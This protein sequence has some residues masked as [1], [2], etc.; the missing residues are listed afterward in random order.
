MKKILPLF[1]AAMI[2]FSACDDDDD[3]N[4]VNNTNNNINNTNNS[5]NTNNTNNT[6]NCNCEEWQY[7]DASS[8]CQISEGRC[9]EPAHCSGTL[10]VC[11]LETHVCVAADCNPACGPFEDCVLDENDN[12]ECVDKTLAWQHFPITIV[13][14]IVNGTSL[15]SPVDGISFAVRETTGEI[16][17]SF[18]SDYDDPNEVFLWHVDGS[19]NHSKKLLS[20]TPFTGTTAFCVGE[21]NWCQF[22]AWDEANDS[23]V[24][25]GPSTDAFMSVSATTWEAT[26]T[27]VTGTHPPD[28]HIS[29]THTFADGAFYLY[30]STGPSG[31][32]NSLYR[33]DIASAQWETIA[34]GLPQI[35]DNCLAVDTD[36]GYVWSFG[37]RLTTDGGNTTSNLDAV[38]RISIDTG[39]VVQTTFPFGPRKGMSCT[40]DPD[41]NMVFIHGGNIVNDNWNDALN[42]FY[43]DLWVFDPVGNTFTELIP[44]TEGGTLTAPDSY[45]DQS[46]EGDPDGPN[47]GKNRGL[48]RYDSA[49]QRL[50]LIGAVPIFTH[51]QIYYLQF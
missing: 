10:P 17:T 32:G 24:I 45:G 48:M 12:P 13:D 44:L 20:G 50:V 41:Y 1:I 33:F 42:E 7:C 49:S 14:P 35:D 39:D 23:Y 40:Y 26:Q 6:N 28:S 31:F 27:V 3:S 22:I 30:G 43:N 8:V 19:G 25:M 46:F 29:V 51:E 36:A 2:S 15:M 34:T 9:S 38:I 16:I 11:D 21:E 5:N 4:N 47:F 37:G 18:G